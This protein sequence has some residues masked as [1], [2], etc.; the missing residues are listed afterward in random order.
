MR[1]REGS[2]DGS[3]AGWEALLEAVSAHSAASTS[4]WMRCLLARRLLL[5]HIGRTIWWTITRGLIWIAWVGHRKMVTLRQSLRLD[6]PPGARQRSKPC[7]KR[8]RQRRTGHNVQL[9]VSATS[10]ALVSLRCC[11]CWV[12]STCPATAV[13][14]RPACETRAKSCPEPGRIVDR[15]L[16]SCRAVRCLYGQNCV[17]AFWRH[18]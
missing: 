10:Q 16:H 11:C 1:R 14:E 8:W 2:A 5:V 18:Y 15:K 9:L 6:R 13:D 4:P 12:I 3:G 17:D 7:R